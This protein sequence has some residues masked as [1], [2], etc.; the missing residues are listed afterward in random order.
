VGIMAVVV[1][2]VV[3]LGRSHGRHRLSQIRRGCFHDH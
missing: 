3:G 2:V 1:V